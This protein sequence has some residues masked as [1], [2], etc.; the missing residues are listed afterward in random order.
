MGVPQNSIVVGHLHQKD[1]GRWC[2]IDC[3]GNEMPLNYVLKQYQGAH[4]CININ[5]LADSNGN[6]HIESH[7]RGN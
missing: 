5:N 3:D 7:Y 6:W 1:D 2:M 4:L